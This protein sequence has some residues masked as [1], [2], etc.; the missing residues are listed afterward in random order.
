MLS[1]HVR[2]RL[3]PQYRY[4]ELQKLFTEPARFSYFLLDDWKELAPCLL[5]Q[6][7]PREMRAQH[8]DVRGRCP[9]CVGY[10]TTFRDQRL[11]I[12]E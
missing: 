6:I 12:H 1:R 2:R 3:K 10:P 4:V 9:E 8:H 5:G 7:D 11:K